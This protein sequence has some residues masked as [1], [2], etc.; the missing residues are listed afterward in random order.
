[1][2]EFNYLLLLLSLNPY[3]ILR[4]NIILW[5]YPLVLSCHPFGVWFWWGMLFSI[6]ISP[7][8][9][10]GVGFIFSIIISPLRD[11]ISFFL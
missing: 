3:F 8:R 11:F 6:I 10:L 2:T 7:L 1:M 9:G 5:L 4:Q